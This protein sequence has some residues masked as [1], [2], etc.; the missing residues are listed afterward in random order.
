TDLIRSTDPA[1][2]TRQVQ[3]NRIDPFAN[4]PIPPT[5]KPSATNKTGGSGSASGAADRSAAAGGRTAANR[6]TPPPVRVQPANAPLVK[7]SPIAA[8]PSIPQPVIAPTVSVSGIIQL[9]NEPYCHC[10]LGQ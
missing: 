6:P 7:P 2:R 1:A 8:L 10:A 3:R 5:P 4:L 9:G